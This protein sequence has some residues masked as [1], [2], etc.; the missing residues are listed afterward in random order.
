M[1]GG[2]GENRAAGPS[3]QGDPHAH[4]GSPVSTL[5]LDHETIAALLDGRLK[6][7][8]RERALAAVADSEEWSALFA[9]AASMLAEEREVPVVPLHGR[10]WS[11]RTGLVALAAALAGLAIIPV[12]AG[13]GGSESPAAMLSDARGGLPVGWEQH[14]WSG[15]RS[16]GDVLAPEARAVRVGI[17]VAEL[18]VAA[19][20]GDTAVRALAEQAAGLLEGAPAGGPAA[21]LFRAIDDGSDIGRARSEAAQLLGEEELARG[22]WLGAARIAAARQDERFFASSSR[23]LARMPERVRQGAGP[24]P[25]WPLLRQALDEATAAY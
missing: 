7:A 1:M 15:V 8:E 2:N 10:R 14:P 6:G 11:R 20:D 24:P 3:N 23:I 19:A 13:R 4:G 9:D 16:G 21:S 17:L 5:K 18:Q 25:R 22:E 12:L